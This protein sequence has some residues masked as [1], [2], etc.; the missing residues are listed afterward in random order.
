[1]QTATTEETR[2]A[3]QLAALDAEGWAQVRPPA[4]DW[5]GA[6]ERAV[7]VGGL[8]TAVAVMERLRDAGAGRS[9]AA[10]AGAAAAALELADVLPAADVAVLCAPF[11]ELLP[12]LVSSRPAPPAAETPA[13]RRRLLA[14]CHAAPAA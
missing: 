8:T 12:D 2:F 7:A 14:W 6:W 11:A 10:L 3:R 4:L 5:E 13:R 1:M 9:Q